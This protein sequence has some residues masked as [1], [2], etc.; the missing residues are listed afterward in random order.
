MK[1]I[2]EY[3]EKTITDNTDLDLYE[4]KYDYDDMKIVIC[5]EEF[6]STHKELWQELEC[7]EDIIALAIKIKKSWLAELEN[8]TLSY[9]HYAYI[10][11]YA[12]EYLCANCTKIEK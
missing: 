12:Q 4:R 2:Q 1:T 8:E 9:E 7:F 3:K 11:S 5:I 6:L 10:Q